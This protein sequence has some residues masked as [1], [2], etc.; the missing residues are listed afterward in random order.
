MSTYN[1]FMEKPLFAF[2]EAVKMLHMNIY[3][4][5]TAKK[6]II[7][8]VHK[9]E[10]TAQD[11]IHALSIHTIADLYLHEIL[12]TKHMMLAM[13]KN[14]SV[15]YQWMRSIHD[16]FVK[17]FNIRGSVPSGITKLFEKLITGITYFYGETEP[18]AP[19]PVYHRFASCGHIGTQTTLSCTK[20]M[21]RTA[22]N[23]ARS[24]VEKCYIERLIFDK[25]YTHEHLRFPE[26]GNV[27]ENESLQDKGHLHFLELVKKEFAQ[28]FKGYTIE[29]ELLWSLDVVPSTPNG[30]II[31]RM[32]NNKV[33]SKET[34]TKSI[35]LGAF[36]NK[37]YDQIVECKRTLYS[38]QG[39]PKEYAKVQSFHGGEKVWKLI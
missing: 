10:K 2:M 15:K 4:E 23:I 38:E 16:R 35:V 21:P 36:G 13:L 25:L 28:C 18:S 3:A 9:L 14:D 37:D 8:Y 5:S 19:F 22:K 27:D 11:P 1:K 24:R 12:Q 26:R 7:A 32:K 31:S 33:V 20:G 17:I 29:I 6:D 39:A 34:Y 30:V